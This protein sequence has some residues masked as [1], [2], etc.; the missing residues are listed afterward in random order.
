V[1]GAAFAAVSL[2]LSAAA[3]VVV[4]FTTVESS[5]SDPELAVLFLAGDSPA[6]GCSRST[7]RLAW[8]R[9]RWRRSMSA[10]TPGVPRPRAFDDDSLETRLVVRQR[11]IPVL[12]IVGPALATTIT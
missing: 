4:A 2:S 1:W 7:S 3:A 6:N 5:L 8:R 9:Q 11:G 10:W 12:L